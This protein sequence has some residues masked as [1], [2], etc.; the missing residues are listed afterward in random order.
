ML[1]VRRA[2]PCRSVN[3]NLQCHLRIF[4]ILQKH[5]LH[6]MFRK[7]I[8]KRL[9]TA[10]AP[11]LPILSR[12]GRMCRDGIARKRQ[13]QMHAFGFTAGLL[14]LLIGL[15][16]DCKQDVVQYGLSNATVRVQCSARLA[17]KCTNMS[18]ASNKIRLK[19]STRH[20]PVTHTAT[21]LLLTWLGRGNAARGR[22]ERGS[23]MWLLG[24]SICNEGWYMGTC[25]HTQR[26]KNEG[27]HTDANF[28]TISGGA[29]W[30]AA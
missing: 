24:T 14:L 4:H 8:N 17:C 20:T 15:T 30:A 10:R 18:R 25:N 6:E 9:H 11:L 29:T 27:G 1:G 5:A 12:A 19:R 3:I 22:G 13:K 7:E 23:D 2:K 26:N 21:A 16:A 28:K